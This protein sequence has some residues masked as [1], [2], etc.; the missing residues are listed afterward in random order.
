MSDKREKRV[1][2]VMR[3]GTADDLTIEEVLKKILQESVVRNHNASN[4][5]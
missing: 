5:C 4:L 3:E 1:A 2:E